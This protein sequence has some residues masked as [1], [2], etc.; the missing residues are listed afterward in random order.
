[1]QQE[2]MLQPTTHTS[3][4]QGSRRC[5]TPTG[6]LEN[7]DLELIFQLMDCIFGPRPWNPRSSQA[8]Q[9]I[10][11][12]KEHGGQ[13]SCLGASVTGPCTAAGRRVAV[14]LG[15]PLAKAPSLKASWLE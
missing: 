2:F 5:Q 11:V 1:M 3:A 6:F 8:Q 4:A 9:V 12:G 10:P 14:T 13:L 7:V 15:S